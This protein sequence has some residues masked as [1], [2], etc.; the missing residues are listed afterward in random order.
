MQ[1]ILNSEYKTVKK[2]I[3][4][5]GADKDAWVPLNDLGTYN[6]TE[7]INID[8]EI[9]VIDLDRLIS[10]N[11]VI[12]IV[13]G[14]RSDSLLVTSLHLAVRMGH[15]HIVSLLLEDFEVED[16]T[17]GLGLTAFSLLAYQNQIDD[18]DMEFMVKY[19]IQSEPAEMDMGM[20]F[21][22]AV[23]AQNEAMIKAIIQYAP[24]SEIIKKL[25]K[26]RPNIIDMF[27]WISGLNWLNWTVKS[28]Y[29]EL[30]SK[31]YIR[32]MNEM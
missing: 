20:A 28:F 10:S 5:D 11:R 2:L 8:Y 25:R 23:V 17:A 3:R 21:H 22:N 24:E 12:S 4:D 13:Q 30:A 7:F 31:P 9:A 32:S 27:N 29:K 6:E 18:V 19:F 1:A 26:I 15:L 14:A 16:T